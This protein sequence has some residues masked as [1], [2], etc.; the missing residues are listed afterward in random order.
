[1]QCRC[2]GCVKKVEKAMVC[3]G[4]VSGVETSVADVDSWIVAVTGKVNPAKLCHWLKSRIRKDVKIVNP[5]PPVQ[6]SMQKLIMLLGSSSEAKCAHI[7][8]SAPPLQDHMSW[9][10]GVEADHQRLHLIE[11]KI[12]DLEKVRD[13]LKIKNL[14]NELVAV[15]G[16][17]RKSREVVNGCKKAL[18]DSALNQLEAYH[19]LEALNQSRCDSIVFCYLVSKS[20][21]YLKFS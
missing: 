4:S 10:S 9:D 21:P 17:L 15:R 5:G 1:M 7:T 6:N 20:K 8:P 3:I 16:E 2:M 18:M 12:R 13:T 11:E 14:E 19:K